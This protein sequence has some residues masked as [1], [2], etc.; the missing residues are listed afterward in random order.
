VPIHA[1]RTDLVPLFV[2]IGLFSIECER[3]DVVKELGRGSS[4]PDGQS[5]TKLFRVRQIYSL[6]HLRLEVVGAG[7]CV[8]GNLRLNRDVRGPKTLVKGLNPNGFKS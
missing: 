5:A 2:H 4:T 6:L 1:I 8:A 3:A 7:Q